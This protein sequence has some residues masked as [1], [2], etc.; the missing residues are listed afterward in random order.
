MHALVG[1]NIGMPLSAQVGA[2]DARGRP[3]RRGEQLSARDDRAVPAGDRGDAELLAGSSRSARDGRG[4]RGSE[5]SA[6]SRTSASRTGP[7]STSTTRK[8]CGWRARRARRRCRSAGAAAARIVREGVVIAGDTIVHRGADGQ[9]WPLVPLSAVHLLGRHLFD[10]RRW[11]RRRSRRFSASRRRR[12]ARAVEG[13]TGLEHALEPVRD[14]SR[15][16][17]SSTTRRRRTSRR[18]S[19][20]SRASIAASSS[21]MGGR[22]KGGDFGRLRE[23]LAGARRDGRGDWRGEAAAPRSARRRHRRAR[24]GDDGRG[25]AVWGSRACG[26]AAR[27]CWRRRVRASTCSATTRIAA[28]SSRTRW[29]RWARRSSARGSSRRGGMCRAA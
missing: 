1:G 4:V 19:G 12:C 10:R 14:A 15:A 17:G 18:R 16:S 11:P 20:R 6:S 29:R 24:R 13:F 22:F 25:G 27:C 8:P 2:F 9:E 7:W 3:R 5:G 28:V 26:R 23:P 21:I